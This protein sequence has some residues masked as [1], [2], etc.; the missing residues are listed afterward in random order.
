MDTYYV[1]VECTVFS[2]SKRPGKLHS[3]KYHVLKA[4]V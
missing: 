3:E 1:T 4:T 2:N